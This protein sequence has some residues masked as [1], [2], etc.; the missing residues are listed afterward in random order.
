MPSTLRG[1]PQ[2]P[3]WNEDFHVKNGASA[4][5]S[6]LNVMLPGHVEIGAD[7]TLF[8]ERPSLF[9]PVVL[10]PVETSPVV[11]D[12]LVEIRSTITAPPWRGKVSSGRN[13][14]ERRKRTVLDERFANLNGSSEIELIVVN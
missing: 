3:L 6:F 4:A 1:F 14:A 12:V 9:T 10:N 7:C 13:K 8:S 11:G 5:S 2:M